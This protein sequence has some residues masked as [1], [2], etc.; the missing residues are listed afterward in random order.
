MAPQNKD[1]TSR[2]ALQLTVTL[3]PCSG[4]WDLRRLEHEVKSFQLQSWS[5]LFFYLYVSRCVLLLRATD[6]SKS[7]K[8]QVG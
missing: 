3:R 4:Q 8:S 6:T 2:P 7:L 1:H 5:G